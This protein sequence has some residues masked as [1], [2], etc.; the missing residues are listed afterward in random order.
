MQFYYLVL[1]LFF[2][3]N[4]IY[5]SVYKPL[6]GNVCWYYCWGSAGD[7]GYY[8]SRCRQIN[9]LPWLPQCDLLVFLIQCRFGLVPCTHIRRVIYRPCRHRVQQLHSLVTI[10]M[11]TLRPILPLEASR[12]RSCCQHIRGVGARWAVRVEHE[13]FKHIT[14][15]RS[16]RIPSYTLTCA[17]TY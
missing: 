1:L 17:I 13:V 10:R 11:L 4:Y 7:C 9:V 14:R 15:Q 2:F 8:H 3:L 6:M 16:T 12:R 5:K